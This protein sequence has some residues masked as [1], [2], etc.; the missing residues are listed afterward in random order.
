VVSCR[1]YNQ[2]RSLVEDEVR[3]VRLTMV[4]VLVAVAAVMEQS[5]TSAPSSSVSKPQPTEW[6]PHP[7]ANGPIIYLHGRSQRSGPYG[8]IERVLVMDPD[9]TNRR[10]LLKEGGQ[11]FSFAPSPDGNMVLVHRSDSTYGP[12]HLFL[13]RSDGA[14]LREVASCQLADCITYMAWSPDG[15]VVAVILGFELMLMRPG[16]TATRTLVSLKSTCKPPGTERLDC[17]HWFTS[18]SWSPDG[19]TVA[20]AWETNSGEGGIDLIDA[21]TGSSRTLVHCTSDLCRRGARPVYPNWSPSGTEILYTSEFGLYA[22]H[23]DGTALRSLGPCPS[24]GAS[25]LTWSPDGTVIAVPGRDGIDLLDA[26]GA[27][28]RRV[29]PRGATLLAWMPAPSA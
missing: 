27:M 16:Q 8:F 4:L 9:G 29:G 15:K 28:L 7:P 19:K 20:A 13:I 21:G 17:R 5:A 23:P 14:Y 3:P 10:V 24:C 2:V 6:I 25:P 12:G 18:P 1:T 22:I 11:F 26:N